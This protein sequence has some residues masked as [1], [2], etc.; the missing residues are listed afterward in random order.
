MEIEFNPGRVPTTGPS[1]SAPRQAAAAT[2]GTS[3]QN[4]EAV[5]EQLKGL[6]AIRPEKVQLG[7]FK[8]EVFEPPKHLTVAVANGT[9]RGSGGGP[10][11]APASVEYRSFALAFL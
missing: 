5:Q 3:F 8:I 2:D 10:A 9:D 11:K 4:A 7:V 6:Q 1:Q